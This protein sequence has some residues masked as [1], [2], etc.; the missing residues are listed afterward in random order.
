MGCCRPA[1]HDPLPWAGDVQTRVASTLGN[2]IFVAAYL[3]MVVP[4]TLHAPGAAP[5]AR[6][7]PPTAEPDAPA[8]SDDPWPLAIIGSGAIFLLMF[9]QYAGMVTGNRIEGQQHAAT[10]SIADFLMWG[11]VLAVAGLFAWAANNVAGRI[12]GRSAPPAR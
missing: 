7:A 10:T 4:L 1:A 11:L 9:M 3:I 2:A 6:G 5:L 8:E 12:S